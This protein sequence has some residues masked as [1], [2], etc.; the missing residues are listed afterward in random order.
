LEGHIYSNWLNGGNIKF[1]ALNLIVSGGHTELVL[2]KNYGKYEIVGETLDDAVGEAF[3]KVARLL[4]LGY[5]GGP[6]VS[7]L[8]DI[9]KKDAYDFPRPMIN[10]GDFNF[11]LSGLKTAV[12]YTLEKEQNISQVAV[13]NMCAS[14]QAVA[15]EILVKKTIKASKEF[16]VRSVLLSGGVAANQKL[17]TDLKA[18]CEKN[19]LPFFFP[20]LKYT[21]DNAAMI[22]AAAYYKLQASSNEAL[23]NKNIF[24]LSV[25]SNWQI[26]NK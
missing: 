13:K 5:P 9:G 21:G 17:K 8:A 24:S 10:S 19:N 20:E 11:S 18:V 4:D 6:I 22:A 16:Q 12:L 15:V 1:P 26:F 7:S 23:V 14:F 25:K 2:M 3:D